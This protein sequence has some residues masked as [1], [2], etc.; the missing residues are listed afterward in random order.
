MNISQRSFARSVPPHNSENV[1]KINKLPLKAYLHELLRRRH[2]ND[3]GYINLPK[4]NFKAMTERVKN[5]E[6]LLVMKD[7]YVQY[8]GHR[9]ILPQTVIDGLMMKALEIKTHQPMLEFL[10]F[11]S[12]LLYHPKPEVV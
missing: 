7:A 9:N 6:D 1:D 5:E 11:H 12:E 4:A 3:S 10:K 2:A 8:L